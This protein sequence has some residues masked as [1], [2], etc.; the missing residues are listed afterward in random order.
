MEK[1]NR[2]SPPKNSSAAMASSVETEVAM[3]RNRVWLV[4]MFRFSTRS[5]L[6]STR[7]FSRTRSKITMVSFSE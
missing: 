4:E 7:K 6:R 1:P 2:L 5:A 3:V